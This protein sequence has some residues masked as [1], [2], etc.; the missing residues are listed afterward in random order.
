MRKLYI[1]S[2][3]R[4]GMIQGTPGTQAIPPTPMARGV[5]SANFLT[6]L[7]FMSLGITF[8]NDFQVF[9]NMYLNAHASSL[10]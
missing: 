5:L 2:I 10:R 6:I 7:A 8:W 3:I 4:Q 9:D 1:I